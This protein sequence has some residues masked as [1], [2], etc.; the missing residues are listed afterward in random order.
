M[1]GLKHMLMLFTLIV[2]ICPCASAETVSDKDA[3]QARLI[4]KFEEFV[5]GTIECIVRY[6]T[7]DANQSLVLK[8]FHKESEAWTPI[9]KFDGGLF[10]KTSKR[11]F[12]N[13]RTD[14]WE[15][16]SDTC[17]KVNA[18]C[19]YTITFTFGN[20]TTRFPCAYAFTYELVAPSRNIWKVTSF[21]NLP[22][23]ADILTASRLSEALEGIDI[24]AVCGDT[25]IGYMMTVD[26][27]S[28]IF[29]GTIDYFD[30]R[31]YGLRMDAMCEKYA[32]IGGVN[33]G[34]FSEA[35]PN[36]GGYPY[37][38]VIRDGVLL[39]QHIQGSESFD[40]VVGFDVNNRLIVTECAPKDVD[41]LKLRDALSFAPVL[42]AKGKAVDNKAFRNNYS[43]RTAIGQDKNGRV[44][45]LVIK[46]RQPNSLGATM[47]DL[48]HV[49]LEF[50]AV[51][52]GNMDGGASA[53]MFVNGESLVSGFPS[54]VSRSI[55]TAFLI[56]PIS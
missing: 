29:V 20:K 55:P 34:G 26:D 48:S 31:N 9:E 16:I 23:A 40:T 17:F 22:C 13:R 42:V 11:A 8:Y 52:A 32:A 37:G 46:G 19:D 12:T 44:L 35:E 2:I 21:R 24:Q 30:K 28:R 7:D 15:W 50:G 39:Q 1:N 6:A 38:L 36:R 3:R 47:Y 56:R 54:E 53:S 27:P 41:S 5:F 43:T 4:E 33:G 14:G 51:T 10:T 25:Y 18:Y 49:F 45:L